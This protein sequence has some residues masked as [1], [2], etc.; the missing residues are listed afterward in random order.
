VAVDP[1]EQPFEPGRRAFLGGSLTAAIAAL[2]S[3]KPQQQRSDAPSPAP[4]P[5]ATTD[6]A[7]TTEHVAA[8]ERL[9][10]VEYSAAERQMIVDSIEDQL[11]LLEARRTFM[12]DDDLAP[13]TVYDPRLP[14]SSLP[15]Q[16]PHVRAGADD[17]GPAPSDPVELAFAPL[18]SLG[19]WL[20]SGAVT[21][22]QLTKI[23][24]DR[25][26]RHGP[27]LACV[28]TLTPDLALAQ[29]ARADAERKAGK[30]RGPLHGIP[31]GAKDLLD[32][33]GIPTTW[34]AKT[35]AERI[36]GR[37][38]GVVERLEAAGAVLVA[39]LSLGALAYGDIGIHGR[40]NNPWNPEEGSSGSSAGSAA[41]TAA[42]LVGFAIGSETL[43]SIVS[44]SMR[45][46]VCGLRPSFGRVARFGA[47]ALCWSLDKLGPLCRRVEDTALVLAA[48][49]HHDPRDPASLDVAFGY[50][51]Q[52]DDPG[53]LAG[54]RIG[55][56][57][58]WF[59]GDDADPERTLDRDALAR[60][61]SLG[62]ELVELSLDDLPYA[63][64][65]PIL[66]AEAAAA[67]EQLTLED[68]DELLTWQS[69]EA[70]PNTFRLARFIPAVDLIQAERLRRR[71]LESIEGL[72]AR[73]RVALLCSPS[74]AGPL[75]TITN[76]TGHPS[77]TMRVGMFDA[78]TRTIH[79][80]P[81][82]PLDPARHRVPHGITLW[83]RL[84]DEATLIRTGR[85]L[86][87]A[88]GVASERPPLF[89]A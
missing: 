64:L 52:A 35:H 8:A 40:T 20:R 33:T 34:G 30:L 65:T 89:R 24:L 61:R 58:E 13:A 73:T 17:P 18:T 6:D 68:R 36:A 4:S 80:A 42:G 37:N 88:L 39:K 69:P 25:L 16:A 75:L 55:Y 59:A 67:F 2:T 87:V 23:Y 48:I 38:A 66:L 76:F 56:D 45:T 26:E 22:T 27:T 47:M 82:E 14:G 62:A 50:D 53:S 29:A 86:E 1:R 43:G 54:L 71:V 83:G 7:L 84:F 79:G 72:F 28:A 81:A 57:P 3:C 46:G 63:G 60:L 78:P 51:G 21:S 19:H 44:P 85:A 77:L 10:G 32:T 49:N 12:P 5:A 11:S 9:A 70:W 41:A 74:F 31:W 15:S